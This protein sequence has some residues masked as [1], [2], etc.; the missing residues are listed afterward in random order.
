MYPTALD[1]IK[2]SIWPRVMTAIGQRAF[3][4]RVAHADVFMLPTRAISNSS[5]RRI[6]GGFGRP[7]LSSSPS[8]FRFHTLRH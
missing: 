7:F 6:K 8:T 4:R 5:G 2:P 1:A 3:V